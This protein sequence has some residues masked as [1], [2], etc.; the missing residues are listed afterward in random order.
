MAEAVLPLAVLKTQF[1]AAGLVVG[2]VRATRDLEILPVS[3]SPHF[4][5][6]C[7]RRP[8]PNISSAQFDDPVMEV[9]GLQ[10][11]FRVAG[12]FLQRIE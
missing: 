3:G 6:I 4:D 11:P 9:E 5:V 10:D 1:H 8:E 12:Q 2:K 7:P